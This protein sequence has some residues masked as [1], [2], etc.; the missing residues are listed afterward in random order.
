MSAVRYGAGRQHVYI[1]GHNTWEDMVMSRG[2]SSLV[3]AETTET[4][5]RLRELRAKA[6]NLQGRTLIR[7][8]RVVLDEI[9]FLLS[10][11]S[12]AEWPTFLGEICNMTE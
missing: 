4:L 1:R 8:R 12:L 11:H 6:G 9:V 5:K 2:S 10:E 3:L 7:K